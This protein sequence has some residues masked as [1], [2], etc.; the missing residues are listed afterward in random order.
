VDILKNRFIDSS[1]EIINASTPGY[2]T[3]QEL[4][5]F[6]KYILQTNPDIVILAYVLNDNHKFLHKFDAEGNML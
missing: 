6:K 1:I 5:F 2:T 4:I 3:Y